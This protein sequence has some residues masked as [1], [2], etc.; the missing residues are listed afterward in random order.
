MSTYTTNL[1]STNWSI[2]RINER[3]DMLNADLEYGDMTRALGQALDILDAATNL[4]ERAR[5]LRDSSQKV[6]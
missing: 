2:K 5:E 3:L 6:A 1:S 4:V